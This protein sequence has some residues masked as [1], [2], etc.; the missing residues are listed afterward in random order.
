MVEGQ[1]EH[2]QTNAAPRKK[3][4]LSGVQ[5][6]GVLH[7]GN[8]IGALSLWAQQQYEYK[9]YFMIADLHALTIP[10][11]I[12]AKELRASSRRVAAL[13]IAS[14]IDPEENVIFLQSAVPAHPYLSWILGCV[15]PMGWLERMTQFK[16]KSGQTESVGTGL[17]TYP[18]LQAADILLYQ[19]DYVPV[20]EDQRQHVELT[21]DIAARFNH[22][23]GKCFRLPEGL[24]RTTGARVMGF[25]DPASKM[26]KSLAEQRTGHAVN[27][28][29][30]PN[31]IKKT[32]MSAVTDSGNEARFEHASAGVRNLLEL[33]EVLTK[34]PREQIENRF[35]GQGYGN[36][37]KAVTEAVVETLR[38]IQERYQQITNE[39]GYLDDLLAKG[40]ERASQVADRTLAKARQLTGV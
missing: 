39:P 24:Y 30:P 34:E 23:F 11:S 1:I 40:A 19:A 29:D 14:G 26:S 27:L 25:D 31:V 18:V 20:G 16:T 12:K 9:N 15:T 33:Y 5:P 37:K 21:R 13:Y 8:Y 7:I 3:I 32:I 28:L 4:V 10:E 22:L 38:P 35:H 36:L 6:T 17:F 2:A